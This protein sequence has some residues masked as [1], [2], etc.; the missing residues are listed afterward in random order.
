MVTLARLDCGNNGEDSLAALKLDDGTVVLEYTTSVGRTSRIRVAPDDTLRVSSEIW[1]KQAKSME[2]ELMLVSR[3]GASTDVA[4]FEYNPTFLGVHADDVGAF[5]S[6]VA[7]AI[8]CGVNV[9]PT[10]ERTFIAPELDS[11]PR[12]AT[13]QPPPSVRFRDRLGAEVFAKL[14]TLDAIQLPDGSVV[15]ESTAYGFV[16]RITAESTLVVWPHEGMGCVETTLSCIEQPPELGDF[17]WNPK[18]KTG[19]HEDA[20]VGFAQAIAERSGCALHVEAV[21]DRLSPTPVRSKPAP[22]APLRPSYVYYSDRPGVVVIASL[23]Y[24][25]A[26]QLPDGTIVIERQ[27]TGVFRTISATD[28]LAIS[29]WHHSF[30]KESIETWLMCLGSSGSLGEFEWDPVAKTGVHPDEVAAFAETIA[31]A[32]GCKVTKSDVR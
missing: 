27:P 20:V 15:V 5:A 2:T 6:A 17:E 22:G 26:L 30:P 12:R 13:P 11:D 31:Q 4:H 3:T 32:T 7:D 14:Q 29:P 24:L 9:M 25:K 8:G 28:T 23:Q 10:K 18:T 19:V 16:W 21:Q 1:G